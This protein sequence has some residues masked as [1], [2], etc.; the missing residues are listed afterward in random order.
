MIL[1][2]LT[3]WRDHHEMVSIAC[4]GPEDVFYYWQEQPQVRC[5]VHRNGDIKGHS[6]CQEVQGI[7]PDKH[8]RR[9]QLFEMGDHE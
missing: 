5:Y 8:C 1:P 7:R 4:M 3:N 9:A 6:G 2:S